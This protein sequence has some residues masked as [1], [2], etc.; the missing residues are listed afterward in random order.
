MSRVPGV[1]PRLH[2]VHRAQTARCGHP[3]RRLL[4]DAAIESA[5]ALPA[6]SVDVRVDGEWSFTENCVTWC[7]PP[8][9]GWAKVCWG[10]RRLAATRTT[11]QTSSPFAAACT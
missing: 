11:P 4:G 3:D 2:G 7:T 10:S 8:T 5:A 6:G 9:S 1:L